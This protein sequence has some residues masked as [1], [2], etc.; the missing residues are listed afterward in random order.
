M[1]TQYQLQ[2]ALAQQRSWGGRLGSNLVRLGY[3]KE[4]DL[5]SFLG[6]QL[7]VP[8][9]DLA[10]HQ[11]SP[12]VLKVI[13]LPLAE[14][15]MIF[16][17]ELRE[18][19]LVLAMTDPSDFAVLEE[20]Q[21]V[22]GYRVDPLVALESS[23]R[24]AID[25]YYKGKIPAQP[26]WL[27]SETFDVTAPTSSDIILTGRDHEKAREKALRAPVNP[28]SISLSAAAA[29]PGTE[30]PVPMNKLLMAL[31]RILGEK[32]VISKDELLRAVKE[33]S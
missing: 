18:K 29:E 21:F 31:I 2:S 30:L 3:L 25:R 11:P 26:A 14:K 19:R 7:K 28:E 24:A 23:I 4:A 22:T 6:R 33:I 12:H 32:G 16:P 13:P 9:V 20:V 17:I 10:S 1:V 5:A 27:P 15:Y 8:F